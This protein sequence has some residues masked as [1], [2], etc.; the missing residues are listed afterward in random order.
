M[1][2]TVRCQHIP[3]KIHTQFWIASHTHT[4][5]NRATINEFSFAFISLISKNSR[6]KLH[7]CSVAIYQPTINTSLRDRVTKRP[8]FTRLSTR[9]VL[10]KPL[11][12]FPIL[13]LS[14]IQ[15]D[16]DEIATFLNQNVVENLKKYKKK[17]KV[18]N[19][20]NTNCKKKYVQWNENKL[21]KFNEINVEFIAKKCRN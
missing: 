13:I 20:T 2:N 17:N 21:K 18:M 12:W 4:L 9:Q 10:L 7:R 5:S 6:R 3:G 15:M 1:A 14:Y 19:G 16:K 11:E 8:P